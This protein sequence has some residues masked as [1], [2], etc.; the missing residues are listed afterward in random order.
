MTIYYSLDQAEL[1]PLQYPRLG[2]HTTLP[3]LKRSFAPAGRA[4]SACLARDF[5][6]ANG[7]LRTPE[8][9]QLGLQGQGCRPGVMQQITIRFRRAGLGGV[10][11]ERTTMH[12]GY[13]RPGCSR[14]GIVCIARRLIG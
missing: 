1:G 5:N 12:A 10:R 3:Y 2:W 6:P 4:Q 8:R 7:R 14:V 13:G 11:F 9:P